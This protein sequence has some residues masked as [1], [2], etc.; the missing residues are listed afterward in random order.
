MNVYFDTEFE[1]LNK[2]A[3][4]I[5]IGMV[6]DDGHELYF[7]F[8]DIDE[9]AIRTTVIPSIIPPDISEISFAM[10]TYITLFSSVNLSLYFFIYVIIVSY[11]NKNFFQVANYNIIIIY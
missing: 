7:E 1:G 6:T 8:D 5:S 10:S 3:K 2:D 11:E 9:N 4:L